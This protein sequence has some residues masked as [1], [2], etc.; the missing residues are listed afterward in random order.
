MTLINTEYN[1]KEDSV[2]DIIS[3]TDYIDFNSDNKYDNNIR[4]YD[5][6][7]NDM[8]YKAKEKTLYGSDLFNKPLLN[9]IFF[10]IRNNTYEITVMWM[11]II[12]TI[13]I[14]LLLLVNGAQDEL[15][16]YDIL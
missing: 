15:E 12:V 11:I 13:I 8:T 3:N 6:L 7:S 9:N 1:L 16:L 5:Y 14:I 10:Y 2:K 4:Y